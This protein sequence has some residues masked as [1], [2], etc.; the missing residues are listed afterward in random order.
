[1]SKVITRK[2]PCFVYNIYKN[3]CSI[4]GQSL[5]C[6]RV[7]QQSLCKYLGGCSKF[8][9]VCNWYRLGTFTIYDNR[10]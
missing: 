9:R 8:V 10:L 1:M 6:Y 2:S 4:K 3:I 7:I 5:S